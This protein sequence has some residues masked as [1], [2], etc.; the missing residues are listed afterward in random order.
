M[1]VEE[2]DKQEQEEEIQGSSKTKQAMRSS[3]VTH[4]VS[5]VIMAAELALPPNQ[6]IKLEQCSKT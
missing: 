4:V 1:Q 3:I 2:G 6:D 5:R